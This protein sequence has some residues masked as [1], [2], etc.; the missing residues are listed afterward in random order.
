MKFSLKRV[1]LRN[2]ALPWYMYIV[3]TKTLITSPTIPTNISDRKQIVY[4]EAEPPGLNYTPLYPSRN[5][6]RKISFQIVIIDRRT[7]LGNSNILQQFETLRNNN[8]DI[9]IFDSS[10]IVLNP[11]SEVIYSWGLF[12]P[13]LKYLVRKCDFE[14]RS[15]QTQKKTGYSSFTTVDLELELIENSDLF[16]NYL[17][18]RTVQNYGGM[19]Q[20]GTQILLK[21]KPY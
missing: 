6:G 8:T 2:K 7:Q 19:A 4:A 11:P 21:G 12:T 17:A 5:G 15:D 3:D 14:H 16:N 13:P 1:K 9:N 18:L 20:S 10:D